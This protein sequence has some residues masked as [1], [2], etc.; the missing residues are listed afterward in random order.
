MIV[1]NAL[2]SCDEIEKSDK[3]VVTLIGLLGLFFLFSGFSKP[4]PAGDLDDPIFDDRFEC[5]E[6]PSANAGMDQ[7]VS[8]GVPISLSGSVSGG[9]NCG[10]LLLWQIVS[11][12]SGSGSELFDETTPAAVFIADRAGTYELQLSVFAA[13]VEGQPD[14]LTVTATGQLANQATVGTG[15]GAVGMMNGA[16]VLIPPGALGGDVNVSISD[17][18]PR[19]GV[20][21]PPTA[22]L[23][24]DIVEF[25]PSGQTFSRPVQVVLPYDVSLL[26]P[27]YA[28]SS[29]NIYRQTD[30]TDFNMVGS[31]AD[32]S[33]NSSSHGQLIDLQSDVV[34]V[35]SKS[36]SAYAALGIRRSSQFTPV[37]LSTSN[38]SITLRRPPSLRTSRPQNQN[39]LPNSNQS[40]IPARAGP[41]ESVVIHSTNNGNSNRDFESE[42]GWAA[43]NCNRFFTHYYINRSGEI[44]QI[45]DDSLTLFHTGSTRLGINNGNAIGIELFLNVGEPYDGRQISSLTRL[46]DYLSE[47]HQ[48]PRPERDT[49]SGIFVRNPIDIAL[50]GDRFVAHAEHD[51]AKCDPS[52]TF[53]DS[54]II[55]PERANVQ[56]L[57][58]TDPRVQPRTLPGGN[59]LATP[60]INVVLDNLAVADRNRQHTGVINTQGGD[61]SELGIAGSGGAVAFREEPLTVDSVVGTVVLT[62]WEQNDPSQLGPGPLIVPPG[63]TEQIVSGVSEYTDVIVDGTLIV[64]GNTELRITGSFYLS[65]T[66]QIIARNGDDGANLQVYSRGTPV[67]QGLIDARGEDGSM[68]AKGGGNGGTVEFVFS[69][70]GLLLLPTIITRGGD[71]DFAD[72]TLP[73]GGPQGGNGGSV[74]V[75]LDTSH[76]FIGGG[77]GPQ[78]GDVTVPAWRSGFI[79]PSLL[80]P[81]RWSGDFLPLPPPFSRSSI[82]VSNPGPAERVRKWT[83]AFQSGF[84]RGLLT[85]GGM[86]GW[87]RSTPPRDGGPAGNGGDL[88]FNLGVDARITMR[89]A[90]IVTGAEIETLRHSFFASGSPQAQIVCTSSGAHGGFGSSG[91]DGGDGGAAGNFVLNGGVFN[92]AP[93]QFTDLYNIQAFPPGGPMQLSDD[94]CARGRIDVGRLMEVRDATGSALYRVRVSTSGNSLVGG[95]GGIPSQNGVVGAIGA[96]GTVS[97]LPLQ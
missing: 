69:S 25:E 68:G 3:R 79:D 56:C 44:F 93:S 97:G 57:S 48:I 8:V 53:M 49:T 11:R 29:I 26:P 15:G 16:S 35:Y 33:L 90:D 19:R 77:I 84:A 5:P 47:L 81:T 22:V 23:V 58:T 36:F 27:L 6:I 66:G 73:G 75:N 91:G 37:D 89:N 12:P 45:A 14:S 62:E 18:P 30:T 2:L 80:T 67:I 83:A 28:E 55:K 40:T 7:A 9:P 41:I 65:P 51:L 85:S 95:I 61:A 64:S 31:D 38:A 46:L 10:A 70:P 87:G 74:T 63:A 59:S 54:G 24:S 71:A 60:L 94:N 76:L 92:P 72:P 39:C 42:L 86:G 52:G 96:S 13:G 1:S 4:S 50:G 78:V 32:Q 17:S 43:D 88:Q 82:G 20:T 34:S 21:F